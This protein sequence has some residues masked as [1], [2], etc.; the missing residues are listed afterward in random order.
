MKCNICEKWTQFLYNLDKWIHFTLTLKETTTMHLRH[1]QP[2]QIQLSVPHTPYPRKQ[3]IKRLN[4]SFPAPT[5]HHH[6]QHREKQWKS[7]SFLCVWGQKHTYKCEH[8]SENCTEVAYEHIHEGFQ[9]LCPWSI[10][11]FCCGRLKTWSISS[12]KT[13]FFRI[14]WRQI[15]RT[16]SAFR[17][18]H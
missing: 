15:M 8:R 5:A 9:V 18:T 13:N 17:N 16:T 6:R 3:Q 1:A 7:V 11:K 14:R 12:K 2:H 10:W 4:N